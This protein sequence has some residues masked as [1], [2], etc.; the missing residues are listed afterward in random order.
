[1]SQRS[2][3]EPAAPSRGRFVNTGN[4]P[5]LVPID[6]GHDTYIGLVDP[7]T[8][9]WSLTRKDALADTLADETFLSA[10][11][12]KAGAFA[13]EM[14]ALR[15]GLGLSAVYINPTERCNLNC[16][17]CYI[18]ESMRRGG[19]QMTEAELFR[20]LEILHGY[21]DGKMP[22]GRLPQV[23]FHGAEPLMCRQIIYKAIE[24]YS[25][26]FRFGVQTNG[27]LLDAEGAALLRETGTSVGLSLDAPVAGIAD[28]T[29]KSWMGDS[30]F[31]KT[32]EAMR[33]LKGY[34]SYSVI[35]TVTSENMAHLSSLVD[36]FHEQEVPTT[37]LNMVRCTMPNARSIKP[38]DEAVFPCFEAAIRRTHE[39][40]RQTG[41][42]LVVANFANILISIIAPSAR[43]LM[44]DI[45]PCGGGRVFFALAPDGSMYPCSEFIGL[46]EFCGGNLFEDE[47]D[48]VLES[49]PFRRVTGRRVE[50]IE[51]CAGCAVRHF[52]GAPCPAEANEMRGG[53]D[54]PGAFCEFYEEQV[55]LALRL[56]ADGVADDFL[57]DGWDKDTETVFD[58][59]RL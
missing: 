46:P 6:I 55:R 7:D 39:L 59:D 4:G 24:R 41:R 9:F 47:I 53:L 27:T 40:Y 13:E 26:R 49:A 34:G 35:C 3:F 36:F 38:A 51:P 16:T 8:A 30:V 42:K 31:E 56:I 54:R 11:R 15:F 28:R 20:S 19:G 29:R 21:F 17:Y 43:R 2:R 12:E 50:A 18:P 33:L 44:C 48:K 22:E 5:T 45:S 58:A 10:C 37:M 25:D 52:C 1:M 23:I 32:L 14:D 57:W